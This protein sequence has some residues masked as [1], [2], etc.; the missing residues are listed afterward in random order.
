MAC[1]GSCSIRNCQ[2]ISTLSKNACSL[3]ADSNRILLILI[4][5]H[6]IFYHFIKVLKAFPPVLLKTMC[7]NCHKTLHLLK[8]SYTFLFFFYFLNTM[9][10]RILLL[11]ALYIQFNNIKVSDEKK[12]Y[13]LFFRKYKLRSFWL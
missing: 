9:F 7:R 13:L 4:V 8:R 2:I 3:D 11:W 5:K 10:K 1:F 12:T 6:E